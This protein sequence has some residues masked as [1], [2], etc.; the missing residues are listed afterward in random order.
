MTGAVDLCPFTVSQWGDLP[1]LPDSKVLPGER[2]AGYTTLGIGGPAGV[3]VEAGSREDLERLLGF[4]RERNVPFVVL[5][6][7]SNLL[8]EDEGFP[9]IAIRLGK[10][11]RYVHLEDGLLRTG[12]A[13]RL[14]RVRAFACRQGLSGFEFS[15]GIPGTVGGALVMNAG[16]RI[17]S[18]GSVCESVEVL[19]RS[20]VYR[21]LSAEE[22][23]FGYRTSL[24]GDFPILS[25]SFRMREENSETIRETMAL[26]E[27]D[28][29]RTQ[30]AN[31]K[32]AGCVFRNPSGTSAGMLLDRLGFRGRR[33][34]GVYVSA[35]HA[36]YILNDGTGTSGDFQ[37]LMN[38]MRHAVQERFGVNLEPEVVR[39]RFRTESN[40]E[41]LQRQG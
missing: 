37:T 16:T 15:T 24:L 9:G 26:L 3:F 31:G 41:T 4:I 28:R 7:G 29:G 32:S 13:A 22:C 35:K 8:F 17:G 1:D 19:D 18:I 25:A 34:G 40:R 20:G 6:G 33:I 12:A 23:G 5:G 38:S 27:R 39:V 11:F 14:S 2:L 21:T 36:N 10:K 30:P